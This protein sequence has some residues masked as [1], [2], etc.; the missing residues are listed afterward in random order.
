[1]IEQLG[2][3]DIYLLDQLMKGRVKKEMRILDAGCGTGRNIQYL[4]QEDYNVWG[5]DKSE[6]AISTLKKACPRWNADYDLSKF[7]VAGLEQLP[8][9]DA[10]FDFIICSAV[11]HFAQNRVHFIQLLE[12]L[13]RV[14]APKGILWFRM[15]AKHT[16]VQ[17][18]HQL[19]DDV[20]ALPDGSTRYLLD[21]GILKNLM[22]KHH[23]SFLDPFKTI[24]VSDLRTM[25]T[26]VL[27][28]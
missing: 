7:Q 16:L 12:E 10:H 11:L 17:H 6:Q 3:I 13:V 26:V 2:R 4:I 8:F 14:L 27:K 22:M 25:A 9:P 20:Y 5:V 19:H 18:A 15:T 21:L 23:L 1:M 28:R 24:N